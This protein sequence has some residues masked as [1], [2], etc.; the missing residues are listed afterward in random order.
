M[1][2]AA[3]AQVLVEVAVDSV[4]GARAA[5]AAGAQRLELCAALELGGLTPSL[6]LL[7]QVRAAVALP[8]FAMVRPRAVWRWGRMCPIPTAWASAAGRWTSP[9]PN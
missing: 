6:G 8:V 5:A 9:A 4:A 3:N 2:A 1:P 7:E